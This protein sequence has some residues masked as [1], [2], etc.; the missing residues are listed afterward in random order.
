[1]GG[2]VMEVVKNSRGEWCS[3]E[4]IR[5]D[6]YEPAHDVRILHPIEGVPKTATARQAMAHLALN[7]EGREE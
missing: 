7:Q 2:A 1:M 4:R 5:R 6:D 3:V